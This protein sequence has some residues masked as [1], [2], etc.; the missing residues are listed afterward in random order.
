M[1]FHRPSPVVEVARFCPE[2]DGRY[3]VSLGK[4]I[5]ASQIFMF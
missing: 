1:P 2:R 5:K 4:I 3:P